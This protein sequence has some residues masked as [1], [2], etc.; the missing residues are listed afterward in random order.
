MRYY[1]QKSH[2]GRKFYFITILAIIITTI[3][4]FTYFFNKRVFPAVLQV[5]EVKVKSR[6]T[7]IINKTSLDL[8]DDKFNYDQ[9]IIIDRDSQNNINLIR[10]NTVKLNA[11]ASQLSID[12]N[13]KLDNM[14][15]VGIKAPLGWMSRNSTFYHLGPSI[16]VN[17]EPIGNVD[18]SYETKFES[19]GINQTRHK[20]YLNVKAR[21][22]VTVPM[23]TDDVMI[24]CQI[25]VA[26][27]IIVGKIPETAINLG[28]K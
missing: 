23:H 27:T 18:V 16:T 25:P 4:L 9:L 12:C 8:V 15:K 7:E 2:M 20:I 28:E 17:I 21:V 10:A 11:L 26:E 1:T 22:R 6:S 5:A 14:G 3:S 19:A 24:K 13:K